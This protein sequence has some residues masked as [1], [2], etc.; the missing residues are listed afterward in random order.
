MDG[1]SKHTKWFYWQST[2]KDVKENKCRL[3]QHDVV[4]SL[5]PKW[6]GGGLLSAHLTSNSPTL[7]LHHI[8]WER[9]KCPIDGLFFLE[10]QGAV[11]GQREARCMGIRCH[12]PADSDALLR[13][14]GHVSVNMHYKIPKTN[15]RDWPERGNVCVSRGRDSALVANEEGQVIKLSWACVSLPLSNTVWNDQWAKIKW[16]QAKIGSLMKMDCVLTHSSQCL[17]VSER[18]GRGQGDTAG[19]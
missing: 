17:S 19:R 13:S 15:A 11:R 1:N 5:T 14:G 4:R 2:S 3:S 9:F 8:C 10:R 7:D 16:S 18:T 6:N 12:C